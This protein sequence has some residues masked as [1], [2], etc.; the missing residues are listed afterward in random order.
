[1]GRSG[2]GE[3]G[4][5]GGGEGGVLLPGAESSAAIAVAV[6]VMAVALVVTVAVRSAVAVAVVV[7]VVDSPPHAAR[8]S[9]ARTNN[10]VR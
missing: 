5:V 2:E 1:M 3:G 10:G 4:W 8:R 6:A 7:V 9:I